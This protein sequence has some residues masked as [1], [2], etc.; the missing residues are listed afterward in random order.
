M[1]RWW[2]AASIAMRS[3]V[4]TAA[5]LLLA[6]VAAFALLATDARGSQE[7]E[8]A[9]ASQELALAMAATPTVH[10]AVAE[11]FGR[12]QRDPGTAI[13]EATA[14]MQPYV[15]RV[16]AATRLDFVTVMHPDGTRYT[17]PDPDEIGRAFIGTTAP[18][19]A[20]E[21]FTEVYEGTLGPSVRAV[22]PVVDGGQIVGLVAAGV[23]IERVGSLVVLR[24][25]AVGGML[26][27]ALLIA[28][29][30][31]WLLARRLDRA[32]G[33]K[34]PEELA[35]LF[36]AHEAALHS[37][38]DGLVL[39]E[40]G[41][42]VLAN[43][44]ARALLGI[45]GMPTPIGADAPLPPGVREVLAG[46]SGQVRVGDRW[47]LVAREA[48]VGRA[49]S[50]TLT[51]RDRTELRRMTGELDAVRTLASALR[52]QTHEFDNRMHTVATLIELDQPQQ[53]LEVA[54]AGRDL[55]QRLADRVL[56]D[57]EEPVVAALLLGKSAQA[58]ERSVELHVETHL[59]PGT[60]GID[61][62]DFVAVLGNLIDNAIDAAAER[63]SLMPG[64]PSGAKPW[65]E[66]YLDEVDGAIVL[67]VSDS[68]AG[69]APAQRAQAFGA[70]WST[71]PGGQHGRGFGLS[72]VRETVE[73]LGGSVDIG[74]GEGDAGAVV[75]VLLPRPRG[76][77]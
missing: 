34:A 62:V 45:G 36:A 61:P 29:L 75:T 57:D 76:A 77:R 67:Q 68:G 39:V 19:L 16:R 10:E 48:A 51:I 60:H 72:I 46:G 6:A 33:G 43:D 32:T 74:D 40:H 70:G 50:T 15:E 23:T 59:E 30:G 21:T 44:R 31:A 26:A 35:R 73:R 69:L 55:G 54:T 22:T 1:R 56:G 53:A 3:F 4:Q 49:A 12:Y 17:H 13:A 5:L 58:H 28:A 63:A 9:L 38:D 27:G 11:A 47:L 66:V 8:A 2:R 42:V 24:L 18:A 71:K 52:A 25:L 14:T 64:E 37:V 41:S 20:G 65:V 7:R